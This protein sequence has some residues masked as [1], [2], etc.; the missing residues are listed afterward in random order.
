MPKG[1]PMPGADDSMRRISEQASKLRDYVADT[2]EAV[3]LVPAPPF[4]EE[5]RAKFVAGLFRE[6]GYEP[7]IDSVNN[8]V[9][10]RKGSGEASS[11][12]LV[13]HTDTVFPEDT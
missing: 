11:I 3:C 1:A 13:G 7:E 12:M 4:K 2:A 6:L 9:V 8:V 5:R 10:R